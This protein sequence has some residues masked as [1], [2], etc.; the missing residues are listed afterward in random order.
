VIS[1]L[2]SLGEKE[3]EAFAKIWDAFGPGDQG[4]HLGGF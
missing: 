3:P 4:R 2:E 1:E